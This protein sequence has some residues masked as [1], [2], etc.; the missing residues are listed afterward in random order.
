MKMRRADDFHIRPAHPDDRAAVLELV[1]RLRAFGLPPLRPAEALDAGERR[2]LERFFDAPSDA[3]RLW[4]AEGPG[5]VILGAAYAER[6]VDYFT[7]E[8]HGHL[9]ILAVAAEA[10]GRG[11]GRRLIAAVEGWAVDERFRFVTLHVFPANAHA[12]A[13]YERSGYRPDTVK[14]VKVLEES[15]PAIRPD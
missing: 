11:I 4:V 13:F 8:V 14:Y 1:P 3:V 15:P 6:A 5:G 7:G 2:T 9:G 12:V 10:E